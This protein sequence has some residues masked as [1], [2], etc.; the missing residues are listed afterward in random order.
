PH[1]GTY[2]TPDPLGL[3]ASPN[4][5]AYVPNPCA[6]IDP[7]GLEPGS[8]RYPF[9]EVPDMEFDFRR[10]GIGRP[11]GEVVL[12]GHG[13]IPEGD[14]TPVTVPDGTSVAMYTEH[15][16]GLMNPGALNIET[17]F[18]FEFYSGRLEPPPEPKEVY[19]PGE[20]L[21]D[22]TLDPPV[23]LKVYGNPVTV[24]SPTRLSEL[25]KPG[26]G[27]VHWAA[28]RNVYLPDP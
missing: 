14:G 11:D 6:H 25:L 13:G 12:S 5:H 7:L 23:G 18:K 26:M 19:G 16:Q 15:G 20:Q 17:G 22:Y 1:A 3:A 27:R 2:L 21:P 4:P 24:T 8:A 10:L 9:G 28:C